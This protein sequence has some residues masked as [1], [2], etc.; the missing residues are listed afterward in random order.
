MRNVDTCARTAL[1]A[2]ASFVLIPSVASADDPCSKRTEL[3]CIEAVDCTLRQLGPPNSEYSCFE[4]AN[5]CEKNFKQKSDTREDCES[6][7]GCVYI[8]PSCYCAPDVLCVCGGGPPG[9]CRPVT[10]ASR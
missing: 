8:P 2:S 10:N 5:L 4:S 1:L 9:Q 6:K 3:Q 7:T